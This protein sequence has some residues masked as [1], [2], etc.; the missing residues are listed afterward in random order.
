MRLPDPDTLRPGRRGWLA[1]LGAAVVGL[2]TWKVRARD[3]SVSVP[4]QAR[5]HALRSADSIVPV[6][7]MVRPA[8]DSVKRHG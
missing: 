8:P 5:P 4:G 3:G 1:A 7:I 2:A 6:K